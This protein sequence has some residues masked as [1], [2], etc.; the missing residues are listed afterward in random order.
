MSLHK[1]HTFLKDNNQ[2]ILD[3]WINDSLKLNYVRV[4]NKNSGMFFMI[5][6]SE[7]DIEVDK[8]DPILVERNIKIYQLSKVEYDNEEYSEKIILMYDKFLQ[9]FPE[10]RKGFLIQVSNYII[11]N[12]DKIYKILNFSD[13][14][15]QTI[16][17]VR[18]LEWFHDNLNLIEHDISRV[19]YSII[20]KTEKMY[21]NFINSESNF[22]NGEKDMKTIS[23]IW[24]YFKEKYDNYEKFKNLYLEITKS[25][26]KLKNQ[27]IE[28]ENLSHSGGFDFNDSLRKQSKKQFLRKKLNELFNLRCKSV[29]DLNIFWNLSYHILLEFMYFIMEITVLISRYHT[30]FIELDTIIPPLSVFN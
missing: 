13:N 2:D 17:W 14:S 25:E 28:I 29:I 23:K 11:I 8:T 18:E 3:Y 15:Y 1:L 27:Y 12:K 7:F 20:Q 19:H 24:G 10:H 9:M 6:I 16:H 30:L 26:Y 21:L 4:I 5:R 22:F